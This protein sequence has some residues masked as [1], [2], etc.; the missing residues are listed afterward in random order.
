MAAPFL[1]GPCFSLL[2]SV[3]TFLGQIIDMVRSRE[4][5]SKIDPTLGTINPRRQALHVHS[6]NNDGGSL[7]HYLPPDGRFMPVLESM[8]QL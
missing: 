3:A 5:T 1:L 8:R 6:L 2:P 4:M 7:E